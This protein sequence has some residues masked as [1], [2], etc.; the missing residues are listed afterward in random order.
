[1]YQAI[2]FF[3]LTY[4][5][6]PFSSYKLCFVD[7]L[8]LDTVDTASLSMCSTRLLFPEDIIEPLDTVT[9]KLV[10]ALATQWI[11]IN[12]IP[13]EPTD[14]WAVVGIAYFITDMFMKRLCGNNEYRYRQKRASDRVCDLDIARPSLY[15]TGALLF[16]NHA[17]LDFMALKAPLVLFILDRRLAKASG[18]SGLSRII[19]RVFLNAKVGDLANG[20]ITTAYFLRT[21]EKLGHAK[22][23]TFFN[24]W[25]YG[26][27]CPRFY[28]TQRFNKKK[29]VVEMLIRQVQGDQNPSRDLDTGTFM[30]DVKEETHNV[31]AGEVQL[32]FTGPMTIRIHE[33]D[34]TPYEHIVEIKEAVTKFDIPY[35]TKYKRLKRSRRQKERA[36]AVTGVDFAADAQDDVLLY[37]LG[38][39]LQSEEEVA[40]WRLVDWSK[41]DEDR[42][43][44]E[45]Y[46]WIRMDADFEWI[47]K[48]SINMPGYM[49]LSQLQQ[50]R[51]VV[52]QLEVSNIT[53]LTCSH[54]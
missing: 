39:V 10:H 12:I 13:K 4:G 32:A 54:C 30:R 2:D 15:D 34:G 28:V 47:C 21:C 36:A 46:E 40:D 31:Y 11:G 19:S 23:D 53:V 52:A 48:M 6:Y 38:D 3:T 50:D 45:S 24:Q 18:S 33:A 9:R 43:S 35:N 27:G 14:M 22:L 42:M 41:E 17:E 16:L 8:V 26:A 7:D 51:D 49:Y 20:A 25:V 29:L 5:S 1:M 44:Q 37:C